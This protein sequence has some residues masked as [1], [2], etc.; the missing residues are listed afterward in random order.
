MPTCLDA[1]KAVPS[2]VEIAFQGACQ[3]I[4][5]AGTSGF[6]LET[7]CQVVIPEQTFSTFY[8][9]GCT[10]DVVTRDVYDA[11][12]GDCTGVCPQPSLA[13]S[14]S[15]SNPPSKSPTSSKSP[16]ALPTITGVHPFTPPPS[17]SSPT[18]SSP[19]PIGVGD[20]EKKQLAPG[21]YLYRQKTSNPLGYQYSFQND[22][23]NDYE[24]SMDFAGST[25]VKLIGTNEMKAMIIAA[26]TERV[27]VATVVQQDQGASI[28][29]KT[30][31]GVREL[32][33]V[34]GDAHSVASNNAAAAKS[35]LDEI[36]ADPN[37]VKVV[38]EAECKKLKDAGTSGIAL[39]DHCEAIQK[40]ADVGFSLLYSGCIG[41]V[42]TEDIYSSVKGECENVCTPNDASSP[43][44]AAKSCLDAIKAD[45]NKVKAVY[46]A[47][48]KKLKDA[49]TSGIALED[50]CE[51][52]QKDAV[53]GFSVLYSFCIGDVK[54]ED[55]YSSVKGECENACTLNEPCSES[56][57]CAGCNEYTL[58][59]E[60]NALEGYSCSLSGDECKVPLGR[61]NL[62]ETSDWTCRYDPVPPTAN[63]SGQ[64]ISCLDAIKA[65]PTPMVPKYQADC[66]AL[67]ANFTPPTTLADH[68]DSEVPPDQLW[69]YGCN[70]A[71]K[72]RDIYDIVGGD[73]ETSCPP[74]TPE[75]YRVISPGCVTGS[76]VSIKKNLTVQECANLCDANLSC[77]AFEYS[78][79][80][81]GSE[82]Y[83]KQEC[84]L[85]DNAEYKQ[86][87]GKKYNQNLYLLYDASKPWLLPKEIKS[88]KSSV[89]G[90]ETPSKNS[91][92]IL[93]TNLLVCFTLATLI[94][95]T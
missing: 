79:N 33:T 6:A 5:T 89:N 13:P 44:A 80:H 83:N 72:T 23:K 70:V 49:G 60:W 56:D 76:D 59:S 22:K 1:I 92:A 55:I 84:R 4:K 19:I 47:E 29:V 68:C 71:V 31:I 7:A 61:R 32:R 16:T 28:L 12:A 17:N 95:L 38:Y 77:L 86:C 2:T 75:G 21:I 51:A 85:N 46:E 36:K 93:E 15:P 48:C 63:G 10:G 73:C 78:A 54:T 11:V 58:S 69:Y 91:N 18:Q 30:Q 82:P 9:P 39:E 41:D 52:I 35:C 64:A 37:K 34:G 53:V 65:D 3:S 42:K 40:N 88:A 27:N 50:H 14:L 62:E 25:N 45:P 94:I 20:A 74:I 26:P 67:A 8:P 24:F 90:T 87:D 43:V 57:S 66:K 81:G